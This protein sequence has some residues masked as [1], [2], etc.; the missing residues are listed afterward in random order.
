[1]PASCLVLK[2]VLLL[3]ALC[4]LTAATA[5]PVFAQAL[6]MGIGTL[7][8]P[9]Q[10]QIAQLQ[11]Q[12][13]AITVVTCP[14]PGPALTVN[15]CY[16]QQLAVQAQLNILQSQEALLQGQLTALKRNPNATAAELAEVAALQ[17]QLDAAKG[18]IT[19]LQTQQAAALVGPDL[20]TAGSGGACPVTGPP[21][22]GGS[23]PPIP[24]WRA[25]PAGACQCAE[26]HQLWG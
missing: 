22:A 1:V 11:A 7:L 5:P 6:P 14:C 9:L 25:N 8:T 21:V 16:S 17:T 12:I 24:P 10:T 3:T 19:S 15:A 23:P 26:P 2:A 13:A 4:W 18:Q 20:S